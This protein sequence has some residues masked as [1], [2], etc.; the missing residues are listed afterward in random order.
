MLDVY[1]LQ[2]A[3]FKKLGT[4]SKD[5]AVELFLFPYLKAPTF[6]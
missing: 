6:G 2:N 3:D 4:L 5:K 1:L